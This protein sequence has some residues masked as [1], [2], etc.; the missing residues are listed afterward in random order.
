MGIA[1]SFD[2][3]MFVFYSPLGEGVERTRWSASIVITGGYDTPFWS[4]FRLNRLSIS[5]ISF[6]L[7]P[8][9]RSTIWRFSI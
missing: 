7:K 6:G 2:V 5:S 8:L 4:R 3:P 1:S 9:P